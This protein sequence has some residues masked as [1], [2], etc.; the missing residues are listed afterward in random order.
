MLE[1]CKNY[2]IVLGSNSPRRK[3]LLAGLDLEFEVRTIPDIDESY[4]SAIEVKNVP[5]YL[6]NKKAAFY[7]TNLESDELLITADTI[8][9][10]FNGK[11]LNKPQNK[12]EAIAMLRCLSGKMHQVI[13]GVCLTTK[14]K[15]ESFSVSS[16]VRFGTLTDEEI[17]YYVE[18]YRPYDKAG[19]YGI[20]EWIGYVGVE[21]IHGSFYNVMGLPVQ[22]LYQKLKDFC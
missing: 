21:S 8:V 18:H 3:E 10:L 11:V 9:C 16:E 14:N 19:A 7:R 2:R 5:V 6:A 12:E 22:K 15:S 13:T 17:M 4:P 20:Q 1:N